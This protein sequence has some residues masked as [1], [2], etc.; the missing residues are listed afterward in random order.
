MKYY[1]ISWCL[2]KVPKIEIDSE[3]FLALQDARNILIGAL[4]I[5]EK[6][7]LLFSNYLELEKDCLNYATECM[8]KGSL[9]YDEITKARQSINRRLVN[10]LTSTRL[11]TD[12]IQQNIKLCIAQDSNFKVKKL[13][14]KQYDENF[15]YR[16]MEA[17]RNYVQHCGL[18]IH[19]FSTPIRWTSQDN[20][21]ELEFRINFFRKKKY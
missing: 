21:G 4:A 12:H 9:G 19:Y 13:M 7:D 8:V 16:F 1:L 20:S 14:A 3:R 2:G 5:E 6:Y 18:A 10:L 11:Y 17:L 15:S